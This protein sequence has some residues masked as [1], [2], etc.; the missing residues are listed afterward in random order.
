MEKIKIKEI[1]SQAKIMGTIVTVG[2]A[3]IMTLIKGPSIGL[4]W[5]KDNAANVH[6]TT[7]SATTNQDPVKGS[8]MITAGCLCWAGFYIL[9]VQIYIYIYIR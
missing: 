4:P 8:I 7:S 5:M 3:M 6:N 9:Q 1:R 2:G